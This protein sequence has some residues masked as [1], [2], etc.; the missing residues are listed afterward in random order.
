V[1]PKPDETKADGKPATDLALSGSHE[2]DQDDGAARHES[3]DFCR[4][5]IRK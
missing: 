3:A 1:V 4:P 2:T 5:S